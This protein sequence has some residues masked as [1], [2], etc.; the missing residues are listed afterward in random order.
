VNDAL[1]DRQAIDLRDAPARAVPAVQLAGVVKLFGR[2]TVLDR[3]DLD[4]GAGQFVALTGPSG[5]GKSTTL[6][7]IAALDVVDDGC[8]SVAGIPVGHHHHES[9]YRRETV[10]IIFQL[11]NLITRLTARQNVELAMFGTH[12]SRR[13]RVD[14]AT[15]L[16]DRLGLADH[17]DSR[18]PVMSGGERQRV[19]IA[20]ALANHP[21]VV[22]AD[23]P[24]GNLDDQSTEVAA[25]VIRQLVDEEGITVLAVS[26]DARLNAYAD[27]LVRLEH[28]RF[29]PVPGSA[30][31]S[32]AAMGQE[33]PAR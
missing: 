21:S 20:R 8:I 13:Q 33:L 9:R 7:L 29:Q 10:G 31:L 32:P 1:D 5:A 4:V 28:G 23:E 16:L 2:R 6:H 19:A 24:T 26:H 14:R 22:L 15:E 12:L 18:P 25:R 17:L 27:R 11:H 30:G 3:A